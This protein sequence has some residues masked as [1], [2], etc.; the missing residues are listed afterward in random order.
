MLRVLM[1]LALGVSMA[2]MTAGSAQS[3]TSKS[4][5]QVFV[6]PTI[7]SA[8]NGLVIQTEMDGSFDVASKTA[9]GDGSFAIKSGNTVLESGTFTLTRLVTFQFYGCGQVD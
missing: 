2:L 8:S 5:F 4:A 6:E 7:T 1:T 3:A 9:S